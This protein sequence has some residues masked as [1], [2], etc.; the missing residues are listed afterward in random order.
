MIYIFFILIKPFSDS[1]TLVYPLILYVTP[2]YPSDLLLQQSVH[3]GNHCYLKVSNCLKSVIFY[4]LYV[5]LVYL[6]I[7][8]L[9]TF[10]AEIK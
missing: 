10:N 1:C 5:C 7:L 8:F 2:L 4:L 3:S 6:L 9:W